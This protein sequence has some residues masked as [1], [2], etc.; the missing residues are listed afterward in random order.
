MRSH[1]NPLVP[2]AGISATVVTAAANPKFARTIKVA[3][4]VPS[5][6]AFLGEQPHPSSD[7]NWF[8]NIRLIGINDSTL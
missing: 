5:Q 6:L 4:Y 7:R 2:P 3:T 8:R 1:Q